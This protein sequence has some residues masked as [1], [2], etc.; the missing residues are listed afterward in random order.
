VDRINLDISALG[1]YSMDVIGHI[2]YF[3]GNQIL[4]GT[5]GLADDFTIIYPEEGWFNVVRFKSAPSYAYLDLGPIEPWDSSE[6]WDEMMK[7]AFEDPEGFIYILRID[8]KLKRIVDG[9]Y[10]DD[11]LAAGMR[12][13]PLKMN[14]ELTRAIVEDINRNIWLLTPEDYP[15][16]VFE[17]AIFFG[18]TY[19]GP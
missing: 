5:V 15:Y 1:F 14:I 17:E 19:A 2:Y 9:R 3:L 13:R 8:L 10:V 16:G 11:I 4:Y 12:I 7:P 18:C 6:S